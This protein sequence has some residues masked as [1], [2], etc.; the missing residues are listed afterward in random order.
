MDPMSIWE[1]IWLDRLYWMHSPMVGAQKRAI[2]KGNNRSA[3]CWNWSWDDPQRGED[4]FFWFSRTCSCWIF[5]ALL[6]QS[7]EEVSRIWLGKN[8]TYILLKQ[9][10]LERIAD[11]W[12]LT[13]CSFSQGGICDR[14][15]QGTPSEPQKVWAVWK[16]KCSCELEF[17]GIGLPIRWL[18]LLDFWR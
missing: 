1:K 11:S 3:H 17:P 5:R 14:S 15:L 4:V 6:L 10:S 9:T 7:A 16:W 12:E 8:Q 18:Q 13:W 2:W